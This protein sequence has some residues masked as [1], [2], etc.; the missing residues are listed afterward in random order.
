MGSFHSVCTIAYK[1]WKHKS[2]RARVSVLNPTFSTE[3]VA[4]GPANKRQNANC[5]PLRNQPPAAPRFSTL[6]TSPRKAGSQPAWPKSRPNLTWRELN[7]RTSNFLPK[8]SVRTRSS[9]AKSRLTD[10]KSRPSSCFVG[11]VLRQQVRNPLP[12][13]APQGGGAGNGRRLRH[14]GPQQE[15]GPYLSSPLGDPP[16]LPGRQPKF[17]RYCSTWVASIP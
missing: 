11:G 7:L 8:F 17:D 5:K 1:I 3:S 6:C 12:D 10:Q 15:S 14:R 13:A 9:S 16:A 2:Q 4:N